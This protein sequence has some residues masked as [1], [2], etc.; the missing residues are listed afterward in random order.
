MSWW[1][2]TSWITTTDTHTTTM[3]TVISQ[4]SPT[5]ELKSYK[6]D[7]GN[8]CLN[9]VTSDTPSLGLSN[10]LASIHSDE[11]HITTDKFVD[12]LGSDFKNG[13]IYN[14]VGDICVSVNPMVAQKHDD[15]MDEY[16]VLEPSLLPP[17]LYGIAAN[18]RRDMLLQQQNQCIVLMGQSGSGK[19]EASKLMLRLLASDGT[20]LDQPLR[21]KLECA[22]EVL[23]AF[24]STSTPMH[25]NASRSCHITKVY[26]DSA[27]VA[28]AAEISSHLL[29]LSQ[30]STVSSDISAAP[31]KIFEILLS[32]A[33]SFP[34]LQLVSKPSRYALMAG[35]RT[36]TSSTSSSS[37]TLAQLQET[38]TSILGWNKDDCNGVWYI[39]AGIL[40]LGNVKIGQ[41][42]RPKSPN[43][44]TS[45]S[46]M[47][48]NSSAN[49]KQS[50]LTSSSTPISPYLEQQQHH[51]TIQNPESIAFAAIL[52][53]VPQNELEDALLLRRVL[54][55]QNTDESDAEEVVWFDELSQAVQAR[56]R[57]IRAVYSRLWS[58]MLAKINASLGHP[59]SAANYLSVAVSDLSGHENLPRN[60]LEQLCINYANEELHSLFVHLHLQAPHED[61]LSQGVSVP[62]IDMDSIMSSHSRLNALAGVFQQL[63]DPHHISDKELLDS[64]ADQK[65]A[66]GLAVIKPGWNSS[67]TKLVVKHFGAASVSYEV[68]GWINKNKKLLG[69]DTKQYDAAL[70]HSTNMTLS[71]R[72][73]VGEPDRRGQA[74]TLSEE[75]RSS[76][77]NVFQNFDQNGLHF[78]C[79][80]SPNSILDATSFDVKLVATQVETFGLSQIASFKQ[81]AYTISMDFRKFAHR[82]SILLHGHERWERDAKDAVLQIC[83]VYNVQG[84]IL[85][86][87]RIFFKEREMLRRLDER[88]L[89]KVP[90][91]ATTIQRF[92]KGFKARIHYIKKRAVRKIIVAL[93]RWEARLIIRDMARRL[94]DWTSKRIFKPL[95]L[96]RLACGQVRLLA[97][98]LQKMHLKWQLARIMAMPRHRLDMIRQ[99]IIAYDAFHSSTK[100]WSLQAE[101]PGVYVGRDSLAFRTFVSKVIAPLDSPRSSSESVRIEYTRWVTKLNRKGWSEK[102]GLIVTTRHI[103]IINDTTHHPTG[104]GPNSLGHPP[105][106]RLAKRTGRALKDVTEIVVGNV[107]ADGVICIRFS[108]GKGD[109]V[110]DLGQSGIV[111]G[112]A[113][114]AWL[115]NEQKKE[116]NDKAATHQQVTIR[117]MDHIDWVNSDRKLLSVE[118]V[119]G[120]EGHAENVVFVRQEGNVIQANY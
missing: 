51:L 53:G 17:H 97:E 89:E 88:R 72:N 117:K 119:K 113:K 87:S 12:R 33:S 4:I 25:G 71:R 37:P 7:L 14:Y 1:D 58:F 109:L 81:A 108:D 24:A 103:Y 2:I 93:V 100:K 27:G 73:V 99:R 80:I 75:F 15:R 62:Q 107:A 85:G 19:T 79:C 8:I 20:K 52:L 50:N 35:S 49:S 39:L 43:R 104:G 10:V 59:V 61:C 57:F 60:G 96:N 9:K 28:K 83:R 23:D 101:W 64:I 44:V 111:E 106:F 55:R 69:E 74:H 114:L 13:K 42:G 116:L 6:S 40:H 66:D 56:D 78:V 95:H 16:L 82:F 92:W 46:S 63:D 70:D 31:Y 3:S 68:K 112:A 22:M 26:Y 36:S 102:R 30:L 38:M 67:T 11:Q 34:S 21:R 48:S 91:A 94:K 105:L 29:S 54:R 76:L 90:W 41:E 5:T 120:L 86:K 84:W 118:F 77:A 65:A 32:S 45:R 47:D 110:I 98:L 115:I 18:A